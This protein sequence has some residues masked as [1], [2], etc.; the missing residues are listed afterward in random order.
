MDK[1]L[2][3]YHGSSLI[4]ERPQ[5]GKG[6]PFNDYGLG[7]YCTETLE[8]AKEWACSM[9]QDGFANRYSFRT[10]GLSVLNLSDG[11]YNILNWLSILLMN[12]KFNLSSDIAAQGKEYLAS[13]F[14]PPYENYDVIIGY[15]ADDSYFSFASAFLNNTIS[16]AQLERAMSL[17][18]LGEQVVLKSEQAF[19]H[20]HFEESI[21]AER[22]IYYPRK[23]IRDSK[24]RA[25][26]RAES[27]TAL[28][29]DV[30]YMIDILRE[31]WKN[32]DARLRG[33]V[34]E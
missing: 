18:K 8:L 19:S 30:V 3:L 26:F 16:L 27:K 31:E 6:N 5:F 17:G 2:T 1:T 34:P 11:S 12:R 29:L 23:A 32:D 25:A 9:E 28:V 33:N 20:L 7:F 15:R 22:T 13:T 4:I 14:L 10:D 24:T 21:P